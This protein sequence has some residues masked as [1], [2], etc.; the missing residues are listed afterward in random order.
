MRDLVLQG[1][2]ADDLAGWEAAPFA[3]AVLQQR[4]SWPLP[5]AAAHLLK[6]DQAAVVR[7]LSPCSR[8]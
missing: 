2:A 3:E 8:P 7:V 4:R 5:W 6:C 1:R